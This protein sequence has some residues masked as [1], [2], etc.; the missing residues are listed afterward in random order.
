MKICVY[1]ASSN[2][3]SELYIKD[4]ESLGYEMAQRKLELVFGGGASGMMGAVARGAAKG[5]GRIIGIAPSFFNVDGILY[6][7]CDELIRTETMRERKKAMEEYSDAFIMTAGGIGTLEEFFEIL[8]LKQLGVHNK[9]I[10]VLNSGGC[11]NKLQAMLEN[12]VCE[13]LI[14]GSVLELYKLAD[15]VDE[16]LDYIESYIPPEIDTSLYKKV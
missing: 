9:A 4:G 13:K 5:G 10:V 11:F 16:A 15:T 14:F 6:S 12:A 3:I 7:G 1:G 8:T 2:E